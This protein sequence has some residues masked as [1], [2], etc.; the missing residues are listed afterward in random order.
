MPNVQVPGQPGNV[1][2][3]NPN[4]NSGGDGSQSQGSDNTQ[5]ARLIHAVA[6]GWRLMISRNVLRSSPRCH[7]GMLRKKCQSLGGHLATAATDNEN[8][9]LKELLQERKATRNRDVWIGGME[10]TNEN[11]ERIYRWRDGTGVKYANWKKGQPS[12]TDRYCMVISRN[13][14]WINRRCSQNYQGV[15]QRAVGAQEVM[16]KPASCDRGWKGC[17]TTE[18]CYKARNLTYEWTDGSEGKF[19]YWV[20]NEPKGD[21]CAQIITEGIRRWHHRWDD[22]ACTQKRASICKKTASIH[23]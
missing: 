6:A 12:G 11:Q 17:A 2:A 9:F 14:E 5:T 16:L 23:A 3:T 18:F 21:E 8:E 15:C 20:V 13:G 10:E 1:P 22:I 19:F 4:T 7:S